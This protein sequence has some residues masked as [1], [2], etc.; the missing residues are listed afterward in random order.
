MV[1][2]LTYLIVSFESSIFCVLLTLVLSM[3]YCLFVLSILLASSRLLA[4]LLIA[5]SLLLALPTSSCPA[6]L[7]FASSCPVPT[8][9]FAASRR[10]HARLIC[11][12]ILL[13]SSRLIACLLLASSM[14]FTFPTSYCPVGLVFATILICTCPYRCLICSWQLDFAFFSS[15]VESVSAHQYI[16]SSLR[17][18]RL[19]VL[20]LLLC[21]CFAVF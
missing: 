19:I 20:C 14:L 10:F 13:A 16:A 21:F 12:S 8:L 3:F 2:E 7:D 4:W 1:V 5:L 9:T 17:L 15:S 11:L 18:F 6:G